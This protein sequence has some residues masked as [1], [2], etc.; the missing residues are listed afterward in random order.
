MKKCDHGIVVGPRQQCPQPQ[1][2]DVAHGQI[3]GQI[4]VG[5]RRR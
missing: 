3:H 2:Q 4:I 5:A 1:Q